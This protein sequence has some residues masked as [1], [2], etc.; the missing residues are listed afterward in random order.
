[1]SLTSGPKIGGCLRWTCSR[2]SFC[3]PMVLCLGRAKCD[4]LCLVVN[5][6]FIMEQQNSI[7]GDSIIENEIL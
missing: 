5:I 2:Y 7:N 4:S 6:L 1:M 3:A